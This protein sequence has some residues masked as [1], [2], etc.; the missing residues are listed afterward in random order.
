M[1]G[2]EHGYKRGISEII[3]GILSA[4]ILNTIVSSRLLDPSWMFYFKLLNTL[5][6]IVLILAMPYWGTTYLL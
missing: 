2:F 1:P 4:I 3:G 6:T 5:G